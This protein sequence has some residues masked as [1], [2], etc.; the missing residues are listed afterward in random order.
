MD[1]DISLESGSS[2]YTVKG[3]KD[4]KEG[5]NLVEI[6]V[7]PKS[8]KET[9][10]KIKVTRLA[11]SGDSLLSD[12]VVK[13]YSI[14]FK[15]NKFKYVIYIDK[16]MDSLEISV[17]PKDKNSYVVI[18]GNKD[19][20]NGSRISIVVQ[21]EDKS[22]SMYELYI[23]EK[24]LLIYLG[25]GSGIILILGIILVVIIKKRKKKAPIFMD[26]Q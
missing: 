16:K 4:F 14:K 10:Y 22:T 2:K 11:K 5:E 8:G 26:L 9:I 20:K 13:D 12:L 24:S 18:G 1:L 23:V 6:V 15:E 19:I 21:A 17:T 7:S 3:N 25:I